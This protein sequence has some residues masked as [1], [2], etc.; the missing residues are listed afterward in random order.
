INESL[1]KIRKWLGPLSIN[2]DMPKNGF[3]L[4]T[5]LKNPEAQVDAFWLAQPT[6]LVVDVYP[7]NS[8]RANSRNLLEMNREFAS[9]KRKS[10]A[11]SRESIYCFPS[12]AKMGASVAFAPW[13]G[14]NLVPLDVKDSAAAKDEMKEGVV[15]YPAQSRL[16]PQ[17]SFANGEMEKSPD[18][19]GSPAQSQLAP[20]NNLPLKDTGRTSLLPPMEK[21]DEARALASESTKP[22][23]FD[24]KIQNKLPPS[25]GANFEKAQKGAN[26]ASLL[27][28]FR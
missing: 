5:L 3:S 1:Q 17:V 9:E 19:N 6:R 21:S 2:S 24:P 7:K 28:P 11:K 22:G 12:T 27:P 10:Q 16:H 25:L 13:K 14:S 20:E 18:S 15:C 23:Q 4:R 26:P 8:P